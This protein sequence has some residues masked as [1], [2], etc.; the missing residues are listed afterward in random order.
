MELQKLIEGFILYCKSRNLSKSTIETAYLPTLKQLCEFLDNPQI[1]TITTANLREF[2]VFNQTRCA[3]S[4]GN[5]LQNEK[6]TTLKPWTLLN[7]VRTI[8]TFFR[9]AYTEE[10]LKTDVS[11]PLKRPK[12]QDDQFEV[13][14]QDQVETLLDV[15]RK[16]S[17]RDYAIVYL[18]LDSGLRKAELINLCTE[19][20][21]LIT[22]MID[23]KFGKGNKTRQV[24]IGKNCRKILWLYCNEYRKPKEE[25]EKRLFL[26]KCGKPLTYGG[27]GVIMQ[28]LSKKCGFNVHCH[29]MRHTYATNVARR[30]PNAFLLSEV[31]GHSDLDT[32]QRYIHFA[33]ND[34]QS[35]LSPMD[36]LLK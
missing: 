36:D 25:T 4:I 29:K 28:R 1:D 14:T 6:D 23:V 31:L 18:L 20:V 9:W 3:F 15:S 19:D 13:F 22:G 30:F 21:N 2:V 34:V 10:L 11:A 5:N 27:L 8:K 26:L 12:V 17:Y 32:S 24:C 33:T 7:Y 16:T 35:I